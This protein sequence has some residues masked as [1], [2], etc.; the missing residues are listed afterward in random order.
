MTDKDDG[1]MN[2]FSSGATRDTSEGKPVYDKFFSC[3]VMKQFAKYMNMNRVQSDG[4][5]RDGDNWQK[6]IPIEKY[7]ES[8]YRHVMDMWSE[9]R[10]Y[11]TEDGLLAAMCGILFNT[12]GYM[13]EILKDDPDTNMQDFDG[14]EPTPEMK[15]RLDRI[16][17]P[18]C[19]LDECI[20]EGCATGQIC[21]NSDV[22]S[23]S[24]QPMPKP[25]AHGPIDYPVDRNI[26]HTDVHNLYDEC[27]TCTYGICG[28]NECC[29]GYRNEKLI[30]DM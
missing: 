21:M 5:L 24:I 25:C 15:K 16:K 26:V 12:M 8:L 6:G 3:L 14:D 9:H 11:P 7:M 28:K 17:G 30:E 19:S 27:E 2:S 4:N 10:G 13:H 18:D 23:V 22:D 1:T 29:P 20:C